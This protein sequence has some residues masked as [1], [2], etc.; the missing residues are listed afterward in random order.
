M[1]QRNLYFD[2]LRGIAIMMVV[3]IHTF[4]SD[5]H[6]V[7]VRQVM[8]AAVPLFIAISG[9]FLSKK[10]ISTKSDHFALLKR[11]IPKVYIP[12][13]IFSLPF[14]ALA[15]H[16][17]ESAFK[18]VVNLFICG[19]S[20]YYFIAFIIQCYVALPFVTRLESK[21]YKGGVICATLISLAWVTFTTW[22]MTINGNSLPLIVY[23]GPLPCWAMFFVLGVALGKNT[24]RNYSLLW[25][26]LFTVMAFVASV[27]SAEYLVETYGKG[28]GIKPTSFI[29]SA[30][31][32]LLLF[33]RKTENFLSRNN[34]L[35]KAIVWIGSISFGIYLM[36]L[37]VLSAIVARLPISSWGLRATL[38][39][40]LTA[41][42]IVVMQKV[43]PKR[44]HKYLG[45]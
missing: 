6:S 25:P 44:I 34:F 26:A 11:Q 13:L 21:S 41:L 22:H 12:T 8:N 16:S 37:F 32:I 3:A 1:A 23:G 20:I 28:F 14:F 18:S 19:F 45:I 35:F 36:H 42:L 4:I 15:I 31:L 27:V 29:Y 17:G 9:F 10:N 43:L 5:C 40:L 30:G 38:T 24:T 7:A 39:L 2:F 33:N